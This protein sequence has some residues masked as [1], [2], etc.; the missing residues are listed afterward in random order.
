MLTSRSQTRMARRVAASSVIVLIVVT[1]LVVTA[2]AAYATVAC[3]HSGT[4]LTITLTGGD[5]V[6]LS[7]DG[8]NRI[9]VNGNTTDT[10]PCSLASAHDTTSTDSID[11]VG[12]TSA[13]DSVTL[14]QANPFPGSFAFDFTLAGGTDAVTI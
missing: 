13:A 5:S 9:L 6:A 1:A 3:G 14:D 7:L 11:V 8:T 4:T 12:S 2:P 10:A